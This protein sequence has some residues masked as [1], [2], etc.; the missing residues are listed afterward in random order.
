MIRLVTT[1]II[2]DNLRYFSSTRPVCI[3][4]ELTRIRIEEDIERNGI[5]KRSM[6][7]QQREISSQ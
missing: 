3:Y 6:V 7:S 4:D 5:L 2:N 1:N